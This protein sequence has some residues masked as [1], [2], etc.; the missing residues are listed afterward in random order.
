MTPPLAI[1]LREPT[2]RTPQEAIDELI[3]LGDT[4]G[5]LALAADLAKASPGN[6]VADCCEQL[7]RVRAVLEAAMQ[8]CEAGFNRDASAVLEHLDPADRHGE[9]AA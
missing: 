4:S 6:T 7:R 2:M 9:A 8:R 3:R 5:I 1:P